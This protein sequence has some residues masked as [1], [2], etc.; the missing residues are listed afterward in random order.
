MPN[1]ILYH[2]SI[3]PQLVTLGEQI[4]NIQVKRLIELVNIDKEFIVKYE[5]GTILV[6]IYV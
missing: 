3:K 2:F 4:L 6:N 1:I 5:N